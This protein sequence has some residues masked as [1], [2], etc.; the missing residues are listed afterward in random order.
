MWD[1]SVRFG[2]SECFSQE[3]YLALVVGAAAA[4]LETLQGVL[5]FYLGSLGPAFIL[6]STR[7]HDPFNNNLK[8]L[9][10]AA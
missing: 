10:L 7:H 1:T 4:W 6:E 8:A 2:G 3:S 5:G 9:L